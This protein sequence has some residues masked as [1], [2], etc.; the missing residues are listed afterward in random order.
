MLI[1]G[2]GQNG[3]SEMN[4]DL[5]NAFL[6]H[7]DYNIIVVDWSSA[8][9]SNYNSAKNNVFEIGK[10][11]SQFIDWMK[12]DSGHLHIIGFDLGGLLYSCKSI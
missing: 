12:L 8:A 1:H 6:T 5:K 11:V 2:Y 10:S 3:R 4:R 7:D 9:G